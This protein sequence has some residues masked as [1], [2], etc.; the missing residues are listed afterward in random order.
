MRQYAATTSKYRSNDYWTEWSA[1]WSE[2]I[3]LISN[4]TSVQ[5]M[6]DCK[7]Q[8]SLRFQSKVAI[9]E[10]QLPLYHIFFESQNSVAQY[11]NFFRLFRYFIDQCNELVCKKLQNLSLIFLPLDWFLQTSLEICLVAELVVK[12]HVRAGHAVLALQTTSL[13][14]GRRTSQT[15]GTTTFH[16]GLGTRDNL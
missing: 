14:I 8:E 6:F 3:R 10:V 15:A 4:Q 7:S 11:K 9:N 1:I 5:R 16:F 2:I 13:L 12:P